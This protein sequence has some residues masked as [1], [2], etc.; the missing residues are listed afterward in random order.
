MTSWW[1]TMRPALKLSRGCGGTC[2]CP[3][4]WRRCPRISALPGA[5]YGFRILSSTRSPPPYVAVCAHDTLVEENTLSLLVEALGDFPETGCCWPGPR[6]RQRSLSGGPWILVGAVGLARVRSSERTTS[7]RLA[8][9]GIDGLSVRR[10]PSGRRIRRT[11]FRLRGGC[12]HLLADVARRMASRLR[13]RCPRTR[14]RYQRSAVR[15]TST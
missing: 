5:N 11:A 12:G 7:E 8:R 13:G 9:R 15:A 10:A 4:M 2:L 1:S 14:A 3:F 6:P